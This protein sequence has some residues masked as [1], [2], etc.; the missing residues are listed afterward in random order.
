MLPPNIFRFT[1][2]FFNDVFAVVVV[3]GRVFMLDEGQYMLLLAADFFD[4]LLQ[5]DSAHITHK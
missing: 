5:K 3:V 1:T 2:P 4:H